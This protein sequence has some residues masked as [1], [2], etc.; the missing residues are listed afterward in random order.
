MEM[1]TKNKIF[2][3]SFDIGKK[4]FAFCVEE[5]NLDSLKKIKNIDLKKR[6]NP[7]GTATPEFSEILKNV[8]ENGK[9]ILFKNSDLTK[10]VVNKKNKPK[11]YLDSEIFHNMVDLLDEY[12]E[13]WDRCSAFIIEK[14]MRCNGMALKLGQHCMSYFMVNYGRFKESIE[15]PSYYKTQILGAEKIEKKTK[16]GKITYK[17]VDKKTR[18]KWSVEIAINILT[19][20]NE[21]ERITEIKSKA[22]R[23]DLGDVLCQLQ[24]FKYLY[25]VEKMEF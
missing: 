24:A 2:L 17:A 14:Q 6:Y 5:I 3:A 7:N 10:N 25:F 1:E 15:F 23:D 9:L 20:R 8:S 22:K 19:A 4:N 18:K 21:L 13:Q 16:K 11:T 12:K